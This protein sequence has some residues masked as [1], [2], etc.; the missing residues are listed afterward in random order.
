MKVRS[1]NLY[2]ELIMIMKILCFKTAINLLIGT[3][4]SIF[5]VT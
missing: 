5:C 2:F 3:K 4:C 1:T